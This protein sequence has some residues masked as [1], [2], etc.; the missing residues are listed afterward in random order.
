M[1]SMGVDE[2]TS[3]LFTKRKEDKKVRKLNL[4]ARS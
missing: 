3:S 2:R 4:I 1:L